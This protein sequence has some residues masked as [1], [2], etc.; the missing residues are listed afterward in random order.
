ML[1]LGCGFRGLAATVTW[2]GTTGTTLNWT[3]AENWVGR[4]AP[5]AGD[6]IVFST[7][8]T[9]IFTTMPASVAYNSIT[10]NSGDVTISKAMPLATLTIGGNSGTDFTI[11]SGASLIIGAFTGITLSASATAT[12]AGTLTISSGTTYN[13]NGTSVKTAV[14]GGSIINAG[15]I[16]NTS[17]KLDFNANSTYEHQQNGGFIPPAGIWA[18]SSTMK[19]TGIT[20]IAT[21][22]DQA[23]GTV[24]WNCPSQTVSQPTTAT[25]FAPSGDFTITNTGTGDFTLPASALNIPNL[26]TLSV[27]SGATLIIPSAAVIS[28]AGTFT[29]SSGGNLKIGSIDGITSS[30]ATG[31]IQTTARN[32]STAAN[33][34]YN[35]TAQS[36][37]S[38]FRGA[39]SLKLQ[40]SGV[41]TF[42]NNSVAVTG[43]TTVDSGVSIALGS[44]NASTNTLTI[45]SGGTPSGTWGS[46]G[47]GAT[48]K[49]ATY[50]GTS[51]AGLMT[52]SL[53]ICAAITVSGA[54]ATPIAV[55]CN[56]GN[57][58]AIN[59]SSATTSGGISPQTL[60]YLWSNAATTQNITGLSA[61]TYLVTITATDANGCTGTQVVSGIVVGQP[62]AVSASGTQVNVLCNAASTG[63]I[64]LS[65]TGG[66]SSYA[67]LWSNGATTQN[68]SNLSARTYSV[69]VTESNGCTVDG[70]TSFTITEPIAVT[71]SGVATNVS[72]NGLSD[73]SIPVTN[74]VGSTVVITN[75][76]N[77]VVSNTGLLAGTY[78]LTASAPNGNN[79]GSCTVTATVTIAE[80]A[81]I[82]ALTQT[83]TD[84]T[85][86]GGSNGEITLLG[87]GG[88]SP[89]TYTITGTGSNASGATSGNFTGLIA[90]TYNYS[91]T[92]AN[93]CIA[94][95]GSLIVG[96][97]DPM[98]VS[99]P[100]ADI[101]PGS[102]IVFDVTSTDNNSY[103]FNWVAKD[104]T[105]ATL[106]SGSLINLSTAAV[107]TTLSLS[108]GTTIN[109]PI[110]FTFTPSTSGVCVGTPITKTI[111]V[112]DLVAPT[113]TRPANITIYTNASC[114]YDAS[115][116]ATGDV[117]NEADNCSTGLQ[118]TYT[119]NT[120]PGVHAGT[121]VITR[122]WS[123]VD[124]CL[125]AAATQ[126]QIIIVND[127]TSP[128]TPTLAD[129]TGECSATASSTTTTDACSGPITGT[130]SDAL[131]YSTQGTHVIH[132]TFT[133]ESGNATTANQNVIVDDVTN[134]ATPT[135]ADITAQCSATATAPTTT[136]NCVGTVTGTTTTIFP[137]ITQ[138]TTVVAWTFDDGNGNS[139]IINQNVIITDNVAPVAPASLADVTA[140]C[141]ATPT[142]PTATDNCAGTVTGTT[143][144]TFPITAQGTMIVTWTFNDG[145]GNT[146]T[147]NQNVTLTDI[148]PPVLVGMPTN[149]SV[150]NET[151]LCT[152][153]VIF[154]SPTA[155][156]N[157]TSPAVT[158]TAGLPSGSAFPVGTTTNIFSVTDIG[159]NI[160]TASFDVVITDSQNPTITAPTNI[161]VCEG[162][163]VSTLG[164]PTATDNCTLPSGAVTN[165]NTVTVPGV[166]PVG[167]TTIVWTVTDA[168]G[169]ATTT[170]QTVTVNA[171]PTVS[172]GSAVAICTG[173]S[174]I[175][176]ATGAD[177]YTWSPTTG[178]SATT[179][180]SITANPTATT[181]YTV[182]GTDVSGCFNTA[183]VTI[184]VNPLPTVSAGAAVA[185]C[186]GS[187][188]TLTASGAD[189]YTW[190]PVDGLSAT[191]GTS[192]TANPTATTTY[193][194]IGTGTN[195][196]TAT[197]SVTV[198]ED[199]AVP[200]IDITNA[201]STLN[202]TT[203]TT[204]VIANA[205]I[206]SSYS[207]T[208]PNGF[209]ATL[210]LIDITAGGTY[211]VTATGINGCSTTANVVISENKATPTVS[212]T[213]SSAV[214]TCSNPTAGLTATGGSTYSWTGSASFTT[215]T[216]T[217]SIAGTYVVTAT[218]TNGCAATS[219]V[220]I[221][222]DKATPTVSITPT[223]AIVL[224]CLTSNAAVIASGA[225]TYSWSG[226][227]GFTATTAIANIT[228]GGTY[229]VAGTSANGCTATTNVIITEVKATPTVTVLPTSIVLTC[230]TPSATV[231]ASG[232]ISYSWTDN[233]GFT[234]TT[235]AI[236]V[237]IAGTYVVTGTGANGCTAT[238]SVIV[239]ENK[240][241]PTVNV[242]G[243]GVLCSG[244][245]ISLIATGGGTYQWSGPN[246]F[247]STSAAVSILNAT[248]SNSGTYIVTVTNA[249]GCTASAMSTIT[250][251]PVVA[252]PTTQADTTIA[253]GASVTLNA[254]GCTG[255]L[256][257][258]R[259][260][261]STPV[262]MPVSPIV[263]T[264]YFAKCEQTTNGI[265]CV[266]ENSANVKVKIS[267]GIVIS[268]K[269]GNWEDPTTWDSGS[270]PTATDK[271]TI[272]STHTVSITTNGTTA[273]K[274]NLNANSV[275]NYANTTAKL[276]IAGL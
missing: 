242:T 33:Y 238:S 78:T 22:L 118:A 11:A 208:G 188:T 7:A 131:T 127:N 152:K 197:A 148:T 1:L 104:A 23:Y 143:I 163:S 247:T 66:S 88:T 36:T 70:T 253:L 212:I 245:A 146:S 274:L 202:C 172:V 224:T 114:I 103:V 68:I 139:I 40:G 28:G 113:F 204:T 157:C 84:V 43:N 122:T 44:N 4:V 117:T 251:N 13:T 115:V 164:T 86:I 60:S 124:N 226:T 203:P 227:G 17:S 186:T 89:Y 178:L 145:Y 167:V 10:V 276:T 173:S 141:S 98:I 215:A 47:S 162:T 29:L 147:V 116:T 45:R 25:T 112:R 72:C 94:A 129:V 54:S 128:R 91:I 221:T 168:A 216:A 261:D 102:A 105:N 58:G 82:T 262:L 8:G 67:Y 130:T 171:L 125:N 269:S 196:C 18:V 9:L 132:W 109:N 187:S 134:P 15:V 65:V 222:E 268:I 207:W 199:K 229:I 59:L 74:S 14:S 75:A 219:S 46:T 194:V 235:A 257:W 159:G 21:V 254:I 111:Y 272:D 62:A 190:S 30:G 263:T 31:N 218:G 230:L 270:V 64:D 126:N 2:G 206:T 158:Q 123:L 258:F 192:I 39:A 27:K 161:I 138:G 42:T 101:C 169:N 87:A 100:T 177:T 249:N 57:T 52:V 137:I 198:T 92:D 119:D 174:T 250:V 99:G 156:D 189:T 266:S 37:G 79:T 191:T 51:G 80:P 246:S 5:V 120:V 195:G 63:S 160:T 273:K 71:V 183:T 93:N 142:A 211:I 149:I 243:A 16:M 237:N 41:K 107:N 135:L 275:L 95:T 55:L 73:G 210:A 108:C 3:T 252:I 201:I 76:S 176:T 260:L 241:T 165:N 166:F 182:T 225:S 244:S 34:T 38:G 83:K 32:F 96:Q 185:I 265:T 151:D 20:S 255:T 239:T 267:T 53:G 49:D 228:A 19:V 233:D 248:V 259:A 205:G 150:N 136:D 213:P 184:T 24:I 48:H 271:V 193:T 256:Q 155:T 35:G 180:V 90:G 220:V 121:Y 209:T 234:A 223:A 200:T 240:V 217:V 26:H 179:G 133:D 140:D 232:A 110:T 175:L 154:I 264:S 97:P 153:V 81:A 236:A 170:N 231:T 214:L 50:F 106:G 12:I 56:G 181:T 69:T 85:C 6:D 144:T 61:G 77:A